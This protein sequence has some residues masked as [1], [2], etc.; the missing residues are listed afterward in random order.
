[1]AF[2]AKTQAYPSNIGLVTIGVGEKAV[3]LGGNNTL[4]FYGFDAPSVNTPKIGAEIP[5]SGISAFSQ[6]GLREFY[7]GCT[8]PAEMAK[9][10]ETVDG[11]SFLFL[12]FECADPN[13][14][15]YAVEQCV[16]IAQSVCDATDLPLAVSGC[17]NTEKDKALFA[18][19]CTALQGKRL[20]IMSAQEDTYQ[21]IA[22]CAFRS[23]HVISAES[24]VDINLAKQL[25]V[26]VTQLGIPAD[27]IVMNPG[28]AAVGYGFEYV[29]STLERIRLA[30]L[31]QSD[32]L[33]QMPIITPV[34]TE[35]WGVK[36]VMMSEAEMPEW[37]DAEER[38]IAMEISTASACLTCGSD[39]VILRHPASIKAISRMIGALA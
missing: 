37:G 11:V 29:A 2:A 5:G 17:G 1:M 20:L 14:E 15:N 4:P 32:D 33:L 26:L 34:S 23:G 30:A 16:Q 12:N 35:V 38:G 13:G 18:A 8:T 6:P 3:T 7:A 10:A 22:T 28:S 39:A 24:S 36:E 19:I 21:D 27:S 25:S 31:A 9:R